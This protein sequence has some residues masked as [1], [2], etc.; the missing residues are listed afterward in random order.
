MPRHIDRNG[1]VAI[2]C[3]N[4]GHTTGH[5]DLTS[6]STRYRCDECGRFAPASDSHGAE[7]KRISRD[8]TINRF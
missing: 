4:C 6:T 3:D 1:G 8:R 5:M 2:E 7:R